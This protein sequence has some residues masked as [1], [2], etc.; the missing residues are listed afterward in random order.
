MKCWAILAA[1][2]FEKWKKNLKNGY[3]LSYI[4]TKIY[5]VYK[6]KKIFEEFENKVFQRLEAKSNN[7]TNFKEIKKQIL[8][9]LGNFATRSN[10]TNLKAAAKLNG[11]TIVYINFGKIERYLCF[12][13]F[14]YCT[15][16]FLAKRH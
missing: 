3:H 12:V 16:T 14:W 6:S 8:V 4:L 13:V 9:D 7:L 1:W 2:K 10:V 15:R 11:K 5:F